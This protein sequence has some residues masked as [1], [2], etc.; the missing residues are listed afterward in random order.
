MRAGRGHLDTAYLKVDPI[1][2]ILGNE[3]NLAVKV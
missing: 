2:A 1:I 3:E